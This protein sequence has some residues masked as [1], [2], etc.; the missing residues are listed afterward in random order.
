M[1]HAPGDNVA[2]KCPVCHVGIAYPKVYCDRC[3]DVKTKFAHPK[4]KHW[5]K[6]LSYWKPEIDYRARNY[7][8]ENYH[9]PWFL[10]RVYQFAQFYSFEDTTRMINSVALERIRHG[11]NKSRCILWSDVSG[12]LQ[13]CENIAFKPTYP[14]VIED[15][16]L[17]PA[18]VRLDEMGLLREGQSHLHNKDH[19][20]VCADGG[21]CINFLPNEDR[22]VFTHRYRARR[23]CRFAV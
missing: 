5:S 23:G 1:S 13:V 7:V 16:E 22:I 11:E 17:L 6:I 19:M 15:E 10:D 18:N 3:G 2:A 8:L 21:N 4:S 14:D 9:K 20:G 12:A